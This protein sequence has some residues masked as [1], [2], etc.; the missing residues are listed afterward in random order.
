MKLSQLFSGEVRTDGQAHTSQPSPAQMEQLNRQIRSLVPGQTITG[1]IVSR[2]GGEVQIR[3]SEDMVLNARVDR[4][5]NME[6][7][8]N[9]TFEVKNNGSALTLSPL[10]TN[11]A[12]DTNV[13]K[14]LDM[15]G[16]PVNQTS[17][18]MTE[19]L[20]AAG[21]PVNKN[22]LQQVFREINSFPQGEISDIINLHKLQMPVN[23]ANVNQM[24][25]YRNLTHQLTDGMDAVFGALPEVFDSMLAEGDV[26]GA[27][28]LY[29]EVFGL[30][31]EGAGFP[32]PAPGGEILP[33]QGEE[34]VMNGTAQNAASETVSGSDGG[35]Q[36]SQA[37][38]LART[39]I[40]DILGSGGQSAM[41]SETVGEAVPQ[42]LREAVANEAL[43]LLHSMKLPEGE[44]SVL[45]AKILSFAGDRSEAGEFISAMNSLADTARL[46]HGAARA[47]ARMFSGENFRE[48]LA[49]QVKNNWM[50]R[51]EEVAS[52]DRVEELYGRLE[53]QLKTL[54]NALESAGQTN[55]SAFRATASMSQ[56]VDFLHQINQMYAYVQLPL[57]LQQGEAHGELYV[58]TNKKRLTEK[59]GTVS[60]LLHLDMEYLGPVDVYVAMQ[61]SKVSTK[62]YLCDEKM[63][64][65]MGEHM[66]ILTQRLKKRGYDC[67]CSMVTRKDGAGETTEGGLEPLLRRERGMVLSQYAFDVRT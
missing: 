30:I 18:S 59:D 66:D 36:E 33:A 37:Q 49:G 53:R 13:L 55:S 20:M 17:V 16:L 44:E 54:S 15:A 5:L 64:D 62:F 26:F 47:L 56:N 35:G 6:I 63:I 9:M 12:T 22:I 7:G 58:Y 29:R 2:N 60:A 38:A 48:F 45:R 19:Q 61:N 39:E 32:V 27:L 65:F 28:N 11:V 67:S 52:R 57:R 42:G 1:E 3:L 43:E 25:A 14:A 23:E 50:L 4:N 41:H 10:F 34:A 31:Q 51:P 21:L 40:P 24:A 8:R 46:S